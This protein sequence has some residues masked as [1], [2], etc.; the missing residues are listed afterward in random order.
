MGLL[1]A[2]DVLDFDQK[3]SFLES[4]WNEMEKSI[5]PQH[6]PSF[7]EWLVRNEVEVMKKS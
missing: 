1:D 7:Y 5:Y 6:A 3:L 4:K 2:V